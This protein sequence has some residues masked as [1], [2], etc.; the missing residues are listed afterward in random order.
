MSIAGLVG[1]ALVSLLGLAVLVALARAVATPRAPAAAPPLA[2]SALGEA[3]GVEEDLALLIRRAT[4]S[5]YDEGE[6]DSSAFEAFKGDLASLYPR[7]HATLKREEIGD[8]ALLFTWEG[9]DEKPSPTGLRPVILCAH[10]DVVPAED[11]ALWTHGPFSGDIAEGCVW[12]RGAQDIKLTLASALHAAERLLAAGFRPRRSVYF[13]FGG[14]EEIGGQRGARLIGEALAS[15]QVRASFLLDEG[16]PVADGMLSFADRPLALVGIAEKGYM[17]VA[18]EAEGSGGHASM[19]PRRTAPGNLARALVA[20]ESAPPRMRLGYTVRSFLDRLAPFAPFPIR[21]LFRNLWLFGPLVKAVFGAGHT[22]NAMIRSTFALTMLQGSAKEN[23]LADKA[24]ANV[25]VRILP[26]ESS[27]Q[28][29]ARLAR[30]AGRHGATARAAHPEAVVEPL[31]ESPVDHEG[32][33][34]IEAALGDSFPEAAAVPFL[35]SAGTDTK[36]YRGVTEAMYRLTPLKQGSAQ[37]E[38]VHGRDERVEIGNL[39]RCEIFY[40]RLISRL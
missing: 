4:V 33:R 7:V 12:G 10:F 21:L 19:P 25:N 40:Q 28:A 20:I 8:R 31:P 38:G 17:D 6:E 35:F 15:R 39:R 22:T 13:A 26:G 14:D 30:L 37:L 5:R 1:I 29:L 9:S 23:V 18:V 3:A 24:K 34:A 2:D 36:H 16:G 27:G 11:A 32:Y